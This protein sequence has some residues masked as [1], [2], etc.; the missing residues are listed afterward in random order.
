MN[1][2]LTIESARNMPIGELSELEISKLV[3]L[4]KD[5][6]ANFEKAKRLK[7]WLDSAISLK[8][9]NRVADLRQNQ[10][11]ATIHFNDG[12]FKISSTISKKVDWDQLKLKE[13]VSQIK[14]SGDNPF[15]YVSISYQVSES[16]FNAWPE[17]IKKLFH[18]ARILNT[19]KEAFTKAPFTK[20][21]FTK[22]TFKIEEIKEVGHE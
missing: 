10:N 9:Q 4:Q 18:P 19:S 2:I 13:I 14:E 15:E 3:L 8:Y 17:Y 6:I 7:E 12:N 1:N 5:T 11:K 21:T 22:E 16:K 20:E